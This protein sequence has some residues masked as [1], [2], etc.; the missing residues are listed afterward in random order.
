MQT[1]SRLR[2]DFFSFVYELLSLWSRIAQGQSE[3]WIRPIIS[4]LPRRQNEPVLVGEVT[5]T[6]HESL[7]V[8]V[9]HRS[10]T[11]RSSDQYWSIFCL[12][13]AL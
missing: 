1:S 4:A 12:R 2:I 9:T 13:K 11:G 6:G 3:R 10:S 5:S 8:L 7:L